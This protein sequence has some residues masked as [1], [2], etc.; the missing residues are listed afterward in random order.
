MTGHDLL[1]I[2]PAIT[3]WQETMALALDAI[4]AAA[5]NQ[6]DGSTH[7]LWCLLATISRPPGSCA[8]HPTG[9]CTSPRNGADPKSP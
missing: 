6:N 3:S 2:H 7:R 8:S 9:D 1:H 4:Y 5:Y